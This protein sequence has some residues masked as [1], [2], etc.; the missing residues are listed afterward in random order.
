MARRPRRDARPATAGSVGGGVAIGPL[1]RDSALGVMWS[2]AL[3]LQVFVHAKRLPDRLGYRPLRW[4][5]IRSLM[6]A[7]RSS[8]ERNVARVSWRKSATS[9]LNSASSD[10]TPA[11][12]VLTSDRPGRLP[13]LR[14]ALRALRGW[15][16]DHPIAG[17]PGV[18]A[19]MGAMRVSWRRTVD[20][21]SCS[22]HGG[23]RSPFLEEVQ[24]SGADP[25]R[26]YG[27]SGVPRL[28]CVDRK[29]GG[30]QTMALQARP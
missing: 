4:P 2:R 1:D 7:S 5:M 8:T 18:L 25:A 9:I 22:C 16:P 30:A 14:Y 21:A 13:A 26:E 12:P 27:P 28:P 15:P 20:Y 10:T 6:S 11:K 3:F 24:H 19:A 23:A 17:R 29:F